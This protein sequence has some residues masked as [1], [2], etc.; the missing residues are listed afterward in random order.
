[1]R[2][3]RKA[4]RD[5]I[6]EYRKK[7]YE[8]IKAD[9]VLL[10]KKLANGRRNAVRYRERGSA[11]SYRRVIRSQ[12][13]QAY[14]GK[15]ECCGETTPEFLSI[16]HMKGQSHAHY[17]NCPYRGGH[18]LHAWLRRNGWPKDGWRLL[19]HNCNLA[20]GFY[21]SCPH[22]DPLRI[23]AYKG[24]TAHTHPLS[25]QRRGRRPKDSFKSFVQA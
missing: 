23:N 1:M 3:W 20:I 8:R 17:S 22:T 11:Y 16:D 25:A 18:Q 24:T 15:C 14:G 6:Q 10:A 9:P 12:M 7:E 21:G 13:I 19:C 2:R 4:N 5:K